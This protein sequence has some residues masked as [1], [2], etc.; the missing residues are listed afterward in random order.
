[1]LAGESDGCDEI[2]LSLSSGSLVSPLSTAEDGLSS[3]T[4]QRLRRPYLSSHPVESLDRSPGLDL[5]PP[6]QTP[7]RQR[8]PER[9]SQLSPG[10]KGGHAFADPVSFVRGGVFSSPPMERQQHR[11]SQQFRST[12]STP[13][14]HQRGTSPVPV[15]C[16]A[17]IPPQG[18]RN[19][20]NTC[21]ANAI[22]QCLLGSAL[23]LALLDPVAATLFRRHFSSNHLI[24]RRGSGSVGSSDEE[25][26]AMNDNDTVTTGAT[27]D[28]TTQWSVSQD[29]HGDDLL[30]TDV[31]SALPAAQQRQLQQAMLRR[32]Q[33]REDDRRI[34]E[35]CQW[36]TTELRV[37]I[38]E[39]DKRPMSN[40]SNRSSKS[41]R[42]LSSHQ[43]ATNRSN[44]SF[45][46]W[47]VQATTPVPTARRA[48]YAWEEDCV[49]D[50]GSI[51][52]Y[53]QRLSPCLRPYQQEDAHEFLRAFLSTLVRQGHH[54]RLSALFD[55]LL[56]SCV[57]C[58]VCRRP[59]LTR[60]RYMDLSLDIVRDDVCTLYDALD[61]FTA[62]ETLSGDNKVHCRNCQ[63]KQ[64]CT[65]GLRL[66]TAPSILV[67]HLKRFAFVEHPALGMRLTRLSKPVKFPLRLEIG[68]YMS[69]VNKARPPPYEL[70]AVLVHQGHS[71]E[72]GHYVAYVK[73]TATAVARGATAPTSQWYLCNDSHVAPVEVAT[74]LEQ[75]AYILVYEVA[76]MRAQHH[77]NQQ[78]VAA[79]QTALHHQIHKEV[80]SD[81]AYYQAAATS[82]KGVT[83]RDTPVDRLVYESDSSDNGLVMPGDEPEPGYCCRGRCGHRRGQGKYSLVSTV[84]CGLDETFLSDLCCDAT[85]CSRAPAA[86]EP[87]TTPLL[88]PREEIEAESSSRS[89]SSV[90]TKV[91]S[92]S[93]N[94]FGKLQRVRSTPRV[95]EGRESKSS[96]DSVDSVGAIGSI[97]SRSSRANRYSVNDTTAH[98]DLSTLGE[99]SVISTDFMRS[100]SST[101]VLDK[102]SNMRGTSA[103]RSSQQASGIG[104]PSVSSDTHLDEILGPHERLSDP[105]V[106][107]APVSYAGGP[108]PPHPR[109]RKVPEG[110]L[111]RDLVD[112]P[113][114][115]T[116]N[117]ANSRYTLKDSHPPRTAPRSKVLRKAATSLR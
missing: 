101:R 62:T 63:T 1:V 39:Y 61:Q 18:L 112:Y 6:S 10:L 95:P 16:T 103:P 78:E 53:P 45:A 47:I 34:R 100:S 21:Y 81:A 54:R 58:T 43:N 109:T 94:E 14:S 15:P 108:T 20:G 117:G 80:L 44:G 99:S 50:P 30:A 9:E 25:A 40:G 11:Q 32:R 48:T 12:H 13:L 70:V 3:P 31:L 23:S 56:E 52:R 28:N 46:D 41:R 5:I 89:P 111:V 42:N 84:L 97:V 96:A 49:V 69:R 74:V 2:H 114:V 72:S 92:P 77:R 82:S 106:P 19:V 27:D 98:D 105:G 113:T 57:T 17:P 76:G 107:D 60:D 22:L 33:Q 116:S 55:G 24:L 67:C 110:R 87:S 36:L 29:P 64:T 71:C 75:Q 35:N 26:A 65:K 86:D 90:P 93:Q 73:R 85:G 83:Q 66:A 59:S 88:S 51:T 115:P 68:E 79:Q 37:L 7:P 8:L 4:H 102:K 91:K 38:N 104:H